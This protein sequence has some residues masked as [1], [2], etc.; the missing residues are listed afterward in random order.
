MIEQDDFINDASAQKGYAI[1]DVLTSVWNSD[2][3]GLIAQAIRFDLER[4]ARQYGW[5]GEEL[6]IQTRDYLLQDPEGLEAPISLT[7]IY[8]IFRIAGTK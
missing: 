8:A 2:E 1:Q 7:Q 3:S 4:T 6:N 5:D